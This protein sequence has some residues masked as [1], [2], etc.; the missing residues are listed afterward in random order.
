MHKEQSERTKQDIQ[1][2]LIQ[3]TAEN[4]DKIYSPFLTMKGFDP[5]K[6]TSIEIL[7]TI[8]LGVIKYIWHVTYTAWSPEEKQTFAVRLQAT[9]IN[10]LSIHTIRSAYII[11]YAGSLIRHQFKTT[12]QTN[13]FHV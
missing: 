3:W 7:H 2:E 8:L 1:E 12:M 6:D 5:V 10:A 9:N 4:R 13:I 11:Q